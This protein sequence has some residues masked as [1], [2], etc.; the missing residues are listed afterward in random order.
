MSLLCYEARWD[1]DLL[2]AIESN[3]LV[4]HS[5]TII[6]ALQPVLP[7]APWM[8][9][10]DIDGCWIP[11]HIVNAAPMPDLSLDEDIDYFV[12]VLPSKISNLLLPLEVVS[13]FVFH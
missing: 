3:D 7:C 4:G 6:R 2:F 10:T 8:L 13:I 5:S 11:Y 9:C 1:A 12:D